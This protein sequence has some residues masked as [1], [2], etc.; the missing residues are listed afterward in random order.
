MTEWLIIAGYSVFIVLAMRVYEWYFKERDQMR[1]IQERARRQ[2]VTEEDL[3]LM[4]K[5]M[6]RRMVV[7]LLLFLPAIL[8]FRSWGDIETPFGTMYWVWW[9]L[10]CTLV[11]NLILGVLSWLHR[12][13]GG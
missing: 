9:F 3:A 8:F 11:I 6:L 5:L 13:R 4:N 7:S 10:I 2:Q 12:T 1:A